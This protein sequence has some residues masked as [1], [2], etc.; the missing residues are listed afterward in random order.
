MTKPVPE[1]A[2]SRRDGRGSYTRAVSTSRASSTAQPVARRRRGANANDTSQATDPGALILG[3]T[4]E[5]LASRSLDELTVTD[6]IAAAGIS[7]P[8]FYGYFESKH[9][10]VAELARV[11]VED[12][13][14]SE[15]MQ[16]LEHADTPT[17]EQMH[18]RWRET[19]TGWQ[20]HDAVLRAAAQGWRSH[21]TVFSG[22]EQA[23]D[24]YTARV[25]DHIDRAR[26]AG[27]A[28]PGGD[29]AALAAALVWMSENA[30]FLS[31]TRDGPTFTDPDTV[32]GAL[33]EVWHRGI[34]GTTA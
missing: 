28:P 1:S 4:G 33:T 20:A 24:T 17:L 10:V 31:I 11:L 34:Y 12:M 2:R 6:V 23:F 3:A 22:W 18:T 25:R 16:W 32:A 26:A 7:R 29:S 8:T 27:S 5:L 19:I 14:Q 21:N 9:A 30:M 13:T 15:W